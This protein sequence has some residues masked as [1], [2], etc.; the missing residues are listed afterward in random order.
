MHMYIANVAIKNIRSIENLK[1]DFEK[2]G[3]SIILTG[4]NGAGKSTVLKCIAMGLTDED[5]TASVLRSM[6]GEFVRKGEYE[7]VITIDLSTNNGRRY[8]IRTK[9]VSQDMFEKVFQRVYKMEDGKYKTVPQEEFPW[10]LIFASGYGAGLRTVGSTDYKYYVA[11]DALFSL[12]SN[13][14]ELQNPELA[15]RRMIAMAEESSKKGNGKAILKY[16]TDALEKVL[17][18]GQGENITLTSSSIEVTI[19]GKGK[20]ELNTLGDGH[21]ST[22]TMLLDLFSWWMLHLQLLNKDILDNREPIGIILIDEIEKHLHPEWQET[23]VDL[24]KKSFPKSQLIA[25][26]NSQI[27]INKGDYTCKE[28]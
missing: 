15:L 24:L 27:I 3:N 23:I 13:S 16:V 20:H 14:A 2:S 1:I 12:F 10:H 8:R 17:Q 19:K 26:T 5:S 6:D 21:I 25:S 28:I 11:I 18:L 4:E 22:I 9:I 7:G